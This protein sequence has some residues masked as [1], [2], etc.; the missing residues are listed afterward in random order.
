MSALGQGTLGTSP[1]A[2]LRPLCDGALRL[3]HRHQEYTV[4]TSP[5][6]IAILALTFAGCGGA[7][8]APA[9]APASSNPQPEAAAAP[10]A[11]A[12]GVGSDGTA[13]AAAAPAAPKV[14]LGLG[15][16]V[17]PDG[18]LFAFKPDR[19]YGKIYLAGNFNDWNPANND[20]LLEDNNKDGVFTINIKLAP[21]TYQYK[22][23]ADGNWITDTHAPMRHPDGFGGQNSKFE[24]K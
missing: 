16:N 4:K 2:M 15:P 23:V 1:S 14:K 11:P 24:V 21:G 18:V 7:A 5:L 10:V 13:E 17:T 8:P 3:N 20:F 6:L 22:Y 12:G 9:E 19:A